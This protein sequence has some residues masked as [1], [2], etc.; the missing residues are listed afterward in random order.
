MIVKIGNRNVKG[1]PI[2]VLAQ[3]PQRAWVIRWNPHKYLLV[4]GATRQEAY[5]NL[6]KDPTYGEDL[7]YAMRHPEF[8]KVREQSY[9]PASLVG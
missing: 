7:S 8:A 1:L 4:D 9:G 3:N 2:T 6:L 5:E